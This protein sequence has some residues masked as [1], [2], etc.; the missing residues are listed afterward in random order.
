MND[1]YLTQ[2]LIRAHQELHKARHHEQQMIRHMCQQLDD[3]APV[4][5]VYQT[6]QVALS[7]HDTVMFMKQIVA[8]LEFMNRPVNVRIH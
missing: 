1:A 6:S 8:D 2:L 5:A 4:E 7:M 3:G